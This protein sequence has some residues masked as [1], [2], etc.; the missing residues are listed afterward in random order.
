MEKCSGSG[1]GSSGSGSDG[2]GFGFG[3][4][5]FVKGKFADIDE[6]EMQIEDTMIKL[7]AAQSFF[8]DALSSGNGS[9]NG[10]GSGSGSVA[11]RF[12]DK[13]GY[14]LEVTRVRGAK[15]QK[16]VPGLDADAFCR[17][18]GGMRLDGVHFDTTSTKTT[19]RLMLPEFRRAS[20]TLAG[21]HET[22]RERVRTRYSEVLAD[23]YERFY[24]T[25]V[26]PC[27]GSLTA[28]DVVFSHAKCAREYRY[29]KPVVLVE[30]ASS[31]FLEASGLRHPIIERLVEEKKGVRYVPN[32][33]RLG[34]GDCKLLYGV[35]SVGKS[36]LL[37]SIALAVIMAQAGMFVAAT[38]FSFRPYQRIFTRT[39]NSDNLFN[40]HSSFV[41]EMTETKQIVDHAD[42]WSLVIADELCAS[43]E[44]DSAV[45]IVSSV[46]KHLCNRKASFIFAT[47]LFALQENYFV[48][49][50]LGNNEVHNVHLTVHLSAAAHADGL[51][52]DRKLRDG[53][54]E[55]RNY[56]LL[57]ANRII[58]S[59]DFEGLTRVSR[60]SSEEEAAA[61]AA[62]VPPPRASRYNKRVFMD[63]CKICAYRPVK[64][65]DIPLDTHHIS[66][67]CEADT[68]GYIGVF[69]KD[70]AHNLV[71]LCKEC[72]VRV[73]RGKV[74]I[75]GYLETTGV[76]RMLDFDILSS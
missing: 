75:R 53:L 8:T 3:G 68:D 51:V 41:K 61:A 31:S 18:S 47:H 24:E 12:S 44:V 36:S 46:M 62:L 17:V 67:Q 35:N 11:L 13:E 7:R 37:K 39:G 66:M 58:G 30:D 70:A 15:L 25:S 4:G 1:L 22:L 57:V 32:D 65:T 27:F 48:R 33:I 69:H 64:K 60:S 14:W 42:A 59:K 45:R 6:L 38:S 19:T 73:H 49:G 63:A 34:E 43:T 56:G 71:V 9:G 29:C 21:L 2:G 52:F 54:P 40:H 28:I 5:C 50:L 23:L 16:L 74:V 26:S 72:H 20:C 55:S 10:S 76:G